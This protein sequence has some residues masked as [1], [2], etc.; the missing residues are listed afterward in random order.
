MTSGNERPRGGRSFDHAG[1]CLLGHGEKSRL[2]KDVAH[3]RLHAVGSYLLKPAAVNSRILVGVLD[4]PSSFLNRNGA[5]P[6]GTTSPYRHERVAAAANVAGEIAGRLIAGI[7][8]LMKHPKR[9]RVHDPMPPG[10]L[11]EIGIPLK[12]EQAVPPA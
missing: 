10:D 1:N 6:L 12:P 5:A 7:E 3:Q 2:I 9:R 4:L 11:L 8:M